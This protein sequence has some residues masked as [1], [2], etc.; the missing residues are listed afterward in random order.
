[1]SW[2]AEE[3]RGGESGESVELGRGGVHRDSEVT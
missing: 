2:E 1:M 3:V